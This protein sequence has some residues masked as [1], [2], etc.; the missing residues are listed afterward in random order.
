MFHMSLHHSQSL[1][2][3]LYNV[4]LGIFST[5]GYCYMATVPSYYIISDTLLRHEYVKQICTSASIAYTFSPCLQFKFLIITR[6]LS[7][8]VGGPYPVQEST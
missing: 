5:S 3:L 8:H 7:V 2:K 1:Q 6:T 4:I